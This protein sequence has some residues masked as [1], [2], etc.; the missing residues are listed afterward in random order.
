MKLIRHGNE[1]GQNGFPRVLKISFARNK[2]EMYTRRFCM[3]GAIPII[4]L[5]IALAPRLPPTISTT[6]LS[7][8]MPS[9]ANPRSRLADNTVVAR[10]FPVYTVLWL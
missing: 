5:L 8:G 6:W 7:T 10:G 9:V 1:L 2:H 4:A 3:N